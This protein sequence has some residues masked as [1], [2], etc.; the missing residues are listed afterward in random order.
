MTFLAG[1]DL[2]ADDLNTFINPPLVFAYQSVAQTLTTAVDTA[3]TMTSEV[4]DTHNGHSTSVNTSRYTPTVAGTYDLEGQVAFAVSTTGDRGAHF[5]KNGVRI[6][7]APY[8][9]QGS[10]KGAA[11]LAGIARCGGVVAMNGTTDYLELY[12]VHDHGSNL[13][14]SVGLTA[15]YMLV[16]RIGA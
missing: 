11:L 1:E 12:A 4:I 9:G 13:N 10:M 5:R 6:T 14:T 3:I 2:T 8:A 16:K 7:S 15:S